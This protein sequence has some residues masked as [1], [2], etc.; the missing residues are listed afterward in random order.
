MGT[1]HHWT[2]AATEE[3]FHRHVASQNTGCRHATKTSS[4]CRKRG[5]ERHWL[6]VPTQQMTITLYDLCDQVAAVP[7]KYQDYCATHETSHRNPFSSKEGKS[8][9]S[10]FREE[11]AT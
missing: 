9:S 2:E 3:N 4:Q 11:H 10:I 1:S 7:K 6:R 5:Q 8:S